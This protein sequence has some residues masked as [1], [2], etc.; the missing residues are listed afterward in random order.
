MEN[1]TWPFSISVF[2]IILFIAYRR[3]QCTFLSGI[4]RYSVGRNRLFYTALR[5]SL[6]VRNA[7]FSTSMA[8]CIRRRVSSLPRNAEMSNMP[9]PLP[10]PTRV[11]LKAFIT[12]PSL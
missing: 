2:I 10:S 5:T 7:Y 1:V 12:S 11:S 8:R 6:S 3:V 4:K 9:G